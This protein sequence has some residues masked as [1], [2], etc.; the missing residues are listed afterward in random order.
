M[1]AKGSRYE[2]TPQ[3]VY[4]DRLGRQVPYVLLRTF[5]PAAPAR[6]LH[7]VGA[8]ERLDLIA[9]HF[10]GDSQQFWRIC[11]ANRTLRPEEIETVGT[12][13]TIPLVTGP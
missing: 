9:D 6:Q 13:L 12:R 10:F 3:A 5:P 1:F 2:R 7:D 4:A 11:D 8:H